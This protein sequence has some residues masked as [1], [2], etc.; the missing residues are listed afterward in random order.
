LS[1]LDIRLEQDKDRPV[2][3]EMTLRIFGPGAYARSAFRLR[4]KAQLLKHS[5]CVALL[6]NCITGS[7]R[8]WSVRIGNAKGALLGPLLVDQPY[9]NRGYG[10]K[11]VQ[12]GLSLLQ[13]NTV[14]FALLVGDMSYYGPLGFYQIQ[15]YAILMPGPVDPNRVLVAPLRG[16]SVNNYTGSVE[17][18]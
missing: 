6:D 13:E 5:C 9:K 2:I 14:D 7:V 1:E 8:F 11:L 4:E 3:E 16:M 10:K 12:E 18:L 17:A 15:P